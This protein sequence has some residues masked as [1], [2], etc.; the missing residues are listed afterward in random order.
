MN[1]TISYLKKVYFLSELSEKKDFLEIGSA[2]KVV[3]TP[4]IVFATMA[5]CTTRYIPLT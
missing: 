1:K 4:Y 5:L 3:S 2:V